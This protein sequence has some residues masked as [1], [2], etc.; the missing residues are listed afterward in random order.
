MLNK[1]IWFSPDHLDIHTLA[2]DAIDDSTSEVET[3]PLE[4]LPLE[5]PLEQEQLPYRCRVPQVDEVRGG[6]EEKNIQFHFLS[7]FIFYPILF[8]IRF[9]FL[10]D[11]YDWFYFFISINLFFSACKYGLKM[12]LFKLFLKWMR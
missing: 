9:Y 1:H 10:S 4:S 7:D 2:G 11:F 8:F 6:F 12:L 3:L 5:R